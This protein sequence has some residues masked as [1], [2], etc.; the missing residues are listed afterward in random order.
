MSS[1]SE[2]RDPRPPTQ[3]PFPLA[4]LSP[5]RSR[6]AGFGLRLLLLGAS[7]S[8]ALAG[9]PAP[10]APARPYFKDDEFPGSVGLIYSHWFRSQLDRS[11]AGISVDRVALYSDVSIKLAGPWSLDLDFLYDYSHYRVRGLGTVAPIP[12]NALVTA[13]PLREANLLR[14]DA[15]FGYRLNRQWRLLAGPRFEIAGASGAEISQATTY[16]AT[17]A[18]EYTFRDKTALTLGATVQTRLEGK[19]Q[20]FPYFRLNPGFANFEKI[21]FEARPNGGLVRYSFTRHFGIFVQAAYDTREYR[22]KSNGPLPGGVWRERSIPVSLGF[23]WQPS[24]RL[25]FNAFG[26]AAFAREVDLLTRDG[27]RY[28]R[29]AAGTTPIAGADF[30]FNF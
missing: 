10:P 30:R 22:L 25:S 26:G 5:A 29:R 27:G 23:T 16:G 7:V 1:E 12:G 13:S 9:D 3:R 18:V 20:V 2:I 11:S 15:I 14:V 8:L 21:D 19:T 24:N 28:F 4:G 6:L 17:A